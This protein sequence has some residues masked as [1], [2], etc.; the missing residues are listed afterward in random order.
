MAGLGTTA[1]GTPAQA[2]TTASRPI[3]KAEAAIPKAWAGKVMKAMGRVSG[4]H[5]ARRSRGA[6]MRQSS[7]DTSMAD[8]KGKAGRLAR[9]ESGEV[10]WV[11]WLKRG[12][13]VRDTALLK[14]KV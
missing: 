3:A 12:C 1:P 2:F 4:T 7:A 9:G 6:A 13:N 11:Q 10:T 14:N 8:P 5:T